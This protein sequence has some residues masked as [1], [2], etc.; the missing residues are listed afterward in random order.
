MQH[1]EILTLIV[2]FVFFSVPRVCSMFRH[3]LIY[4]FISSPQQLI[5]L[6]QLLA[7]NTLHAIDQSDEV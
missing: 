4:N 7:I 1:S 6:V 2:T 3:L 5:R